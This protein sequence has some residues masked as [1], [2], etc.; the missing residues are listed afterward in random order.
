MRAIF[1]FG[2][3][4]GF[5]VVALS[6]LQAGTSGQR[7]LVDASIAAIVSAVLFRWFWGRLVLALTDT[8]KAKRAIRRVAEEAAA[9]AKATPVSSTKAKLN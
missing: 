1:L 5:L 2:G 3:F 8:V 7:I 9:A 4:I 6:E